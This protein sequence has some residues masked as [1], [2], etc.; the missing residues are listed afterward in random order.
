MKKRRFIIPAAVLA[1]AA[2]AAVIISFSYIT[3]EDEKT[4]RFKPGETEIDISEEFIIPVN[5][6]PGDRMTK[7]P[8]V[9]NTGNTDCYVRARVL[10]SDSRVLEYVD[11]PDINP[12]WVYGEDGFYY[13]TKL[14]KRGDTSESIF[15]ELYFKKEVPD[16]GLD[17]E[18]I[19]YSEAIEHP[20]H[21][22][23]C[24]PGEFLSSWW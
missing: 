6:V 7:S 22:G 11:Y 17:F 5:P 21:E 4:N 18:I 8:K 12:E 19:V 20:Y 23:E 3:S 15:D 9:E 2:A 14:L 16:D 10:F 1:F 13:Y 24:I